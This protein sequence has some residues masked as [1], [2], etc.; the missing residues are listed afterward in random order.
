MTWCADSDKICLI[1]YFCCF[2]FCFYC[3]VIPGFVIVVGGG[4]G[5]A[6]VLVWCCGGRTVGTRPREDADI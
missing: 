5:V 4:S 1:N 3:C 6:V 2:C